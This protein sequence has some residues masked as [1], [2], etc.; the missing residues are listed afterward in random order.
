MQAAAFQRLPVGL[1]A[2]LRVRVM[3]R[4]RLAQQ[5]QQL[6]AGGH[7]AHLL[8]KRSAVAGNADFHAGIKNRPQDKTFVGLAAQRKAFFLRNRADAAGAVADR[9]PCVEHD[10]YSF[11]AHK[12]FSFTD[13]YTPFRR[14]LS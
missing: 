12:A 5:A 10:A 1:P 11:F 7:S 9:I 2:H 14:K 3:G 4:G 13:K 8:Q 6:V